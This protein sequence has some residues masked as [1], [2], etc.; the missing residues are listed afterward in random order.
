MIRSYI[1]Y[2]HISAEVR[3]TVHDQRMMTKLELAILLNHM[4]GCDIATLWSFNVVRRPPVRHYVPAISNEQEV[5]VTSSAT[6]LHLLTRMSQTINIEIKHCD[7]MLF[8]FE[9][10]HRCLCG[11]NAAAFTG[12]NIRVDD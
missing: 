7:W 8:N 2:R 12:R 3:G 1:I 5:V 11:N 9:L 10:L 6:V 4:I